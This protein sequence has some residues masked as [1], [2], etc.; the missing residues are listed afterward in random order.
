MRNKLKDD[1]GIALLSVLVMVL[2]C[3]LLSATIMRAS[4]VALL[5]RNVKTTSTNNFYSAEGVVDQ[6]KIRLQSVAAAALSISDAKDSTAFISVAYKQLTGGVEDASGSDEEAKKAVQQERIENAKKFFME[7]LSKY[8]SEHYNDSTV[9]ID[10]KDIYTSVDS[11]NNPVLI[12]E[13]VKITYTDPNTNYYSEIETDIRINAPFFASSIKMA[14]GS[15][16]M[17]IG[18]G[19]SF[20]DSG[21]GSKMPAYVHQMGNVYFGKI[22]NSTNAVEVGQ[23][24]TLELSGD[25]VV[26]NGDIEVGEQAAIKF[27]GKG[28]VE[29]RGTIYLTKKSSLVISDNTYLL[30]KDIIVDGKS[31]ASGAYSNSASNPVAYKKYFPYKVDP[32]TVQN[33]Q[34]NFE[35]SLTS[36]GL[37]IIETSTNNCY[38]LAKDVS[39]FWY[40]TATTSKIQ[41]TTE[42]GST[43]ASENRGFYF[44]SDIEPKAAV[45]FT[46]IGNKAYSVDDQVYKFLNVSFLTAIGEK[47]QQNNGGLLYKSSNGYTY[48]PGDDSLG[49]TKQLGVKGYYKPS[50]TILQSGFTAPSLTYGGYTYPLANSHLEFGQVQSNLNVQDGVQ[51]L[52]LYFS[53]ADYNVRWNAQN[54]KGANYMGIFMSLKKVN[55]T[56]VG[57][58]GGKSMLDSDKSEDID[59][60]KKFMEEMS[61]HY[62][63][64]QS[65]W[66]NS[67]NAHMFLF[68]NLF[69]GGWQSFFEKENTT[70]KNVNTSQNDNL[71]LIELGEWK[72]Q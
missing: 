12:V 2:L 40:S 57:Y 59:G 28:A 65:D 39:G 61:S 4:Y 55:Y 3:F 58:L 8:D 41:F 47:G 53:N 43:E 14:L 6:M 51:Q 32:E 48:D 42:S 29:V 56:G 25:N 72:K 35:N 20:T 63:V 23:Y 38:K 22:A 13:G 67:S 26:I 24:V 52:C 1:S 50:G 9:T 66:I 11:K 45:P 15:Y 46:S 18:S 54:G 33:G 30:C 17:L 64:G 31:V 62:L 16:S 19:A 70:Q 5:S 68:N 37:Y 7:N 60:A 49:I 36:S 27:T 10:I 21:M 34:D 69:N 44:K 71:N